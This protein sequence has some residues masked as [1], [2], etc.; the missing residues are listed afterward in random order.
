MADTPAQAQAH[1]HLRERWERLGFDALGRP[2]QE[3]VALY[4]LEGELMNGGLHQFFGNSSG[5][6][7]EHVRSGLQRLDCPVS[8]GLFDTAVATL[9]VGSAL[10]SRD[11]RNEA[12]QRL[13]LDVD[14]FD[15]ETRALQDLPEDFF[16]RALDDL[17]QEYAS[18]GG[19]A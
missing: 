3:A 14:P 6:L 10:A 7:S 2:E 1:A 8:L 11:A 17:M 13:G 19:D 12:L 5:D 16:R 4:W 15:A 18:L 9:G